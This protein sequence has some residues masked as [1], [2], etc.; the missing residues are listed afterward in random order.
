MTAATIEND[1]AMRDLDLRAPAFAK[2]P[3]PTYALLRA[4]YPVLQIAD[5]TYILS[6]Y[7]DVKF[8]LKSYELFASGWAG[9][10]I[11][12]PKWLR[13]DYRR[14]HF[15]PE[16]DPPEHTQNSAIINKSFVGRAI[17]VMLPFMR[18]TATCL[19]ARLQR[20]DADFLTDF[21]F[22]YMG[23]VLANI[24][25]MDTGNDMDRTRAWIELA[26]SFTEVKPEPELQARAENIIFEQNE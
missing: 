14:G 17:E 21:A 11:A 1:T 22:P 12:H 10:P 18:E 16:T 5:G 26:E 23:S 4:R 13:E 3:Y 8:A 24:T 15:L 19:T 20:P 9:A 7:D 6:R 2:N 25:G